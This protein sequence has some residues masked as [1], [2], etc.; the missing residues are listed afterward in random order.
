MKANQRPHVLCDC[1][2]PSMAAALPPGDEKSTL[3]LPSTN[4]LEWMRCQTISAAKA[5]LSPVPF[6]A[7]LNA[8][9]FYGCISFVV[10]D[11]RSFIPQCQIGIGLPCPQCG[12]VVG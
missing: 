5:G 6:N 9:L 8:V 7:R 3:F 10:Q 11:P 12:D 2:R 1:G 4:I